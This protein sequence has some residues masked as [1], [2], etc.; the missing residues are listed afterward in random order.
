LVIELLSELIG[1][2]LV[3][4]RY[5]TGNK[6]VNH[7]CK[8]PFLT[9]KKSVLDMNTPAEVTTEQAFSN[10][11]SILQGDADLTPCYRLFNS[12]STEMPDCFHS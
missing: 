10:R 3:K 12:S 2:M 7:K 5:I 8:Y 6:N 4:L 1:I 9:R 11:S